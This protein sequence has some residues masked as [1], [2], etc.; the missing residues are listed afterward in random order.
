M[1]KV[2]G[3][4][5]FPG[6]TIDEIKELN[7]PGLNLHYFDNLNKYEEEINAPGL[8][9]TGEVDD[10]Y[11]S[12]TLTHKLQEMAGVEQKTENCDISIESED[13]MNYLQKGEIKGKYIGL[14][15]KPPYELQK[16]EETARKLGKELEATDIFIRGVEKENEAP[17]ACI[18]LVTENE[19]KLVE[20]NKLVLE[21][22]EPGP[23][24]YL[25]FR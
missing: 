3:Y 2:R 8:F 16:L 12:E 9:L 11:T 15:I 20:L 13:Y 19:L 24:V 7:F 18:D 23:V 1:Q 10:S 22:L 5:Y 21:Q 6:K 25:K 14:R 4:I 17:L